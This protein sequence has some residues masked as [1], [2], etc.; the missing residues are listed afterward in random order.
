M[1]EQEWKDQVMDLS[2]DYRAILW[3][4]AN[5]P[6]SPVIIEANSGDYYRWYVRFTMYTGLPDV[7]GWGYH[8][9]QQRALLTSDWV[10]QRGDEINNFYTTNDVNEALA[11]LKKY[12]VKYFVLGQ[13]ERITYPGVGLEKF[14]ALSG[15]YWRP[16]YQDRDTIIFAV[17]QP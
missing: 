5:I 4:Q 6:G 14:P 1:T 17:N 10:Y 7:L 12:N 16:V 15:K 3:M 2:Q 13:L 9:T 11:F 8:E